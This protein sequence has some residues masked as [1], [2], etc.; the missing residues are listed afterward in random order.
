MENAIIEENR[1]KYYHP[2]PNLQHPLSTNFGEYRET[3]ASIK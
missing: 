3:Q 2:D 1:K